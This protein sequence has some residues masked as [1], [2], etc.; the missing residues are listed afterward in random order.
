[1]KQSMHIVSRRVSLTILACAT[2]ACAQS[3]SCYSY[4]WF[5]LQVDGK[6]TYVLVED[7]TEDLFFKMVD[8]ILNNRSNAIDVVFSSL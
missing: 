5:S 4:C 3:L 6:T 1:M 2:L 8:Q 7:F